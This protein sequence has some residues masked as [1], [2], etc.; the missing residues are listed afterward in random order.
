[1]KKT[2]WIF[3]GGA[4]RT[5]YVAG[6][7]YA[8]CEMDLPKPDIILAG[9]G[10]A[11][12]CLTYITKQ[13]EVIKKIWCEELYSKRFINFFRFWKIVDI[14]YL[15]DDLMKKNNPLKI[16]EVIKSDIKVYWPATDSY[17]GNIKYFSNH[18]G[19]DVWQILK[20][21]KSS[22]IFTNTFSVK[23]HKIGDRYYSDSLASS[24]Y[25]YH[26]KKMLEEGVERIIVID[27]YHPLDSYNKN[28]FSKIY[29][30]LRNRH[31]RKNQ[32]RA[33]REIESFVKPE[34]VEFIKISPQSRLA[35][36]RFGASRKKGLEVFDR[37]YQDALNNCE[38]KNL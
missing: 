23:G 13:K 11:G 22:P 26:V 9:S 15:I 12:T 33:I 20:A 19:V 24:R 27:S 6:A 17:E 28:T 34:G 10:S 21:V 1:M 29:A 16:D 31:F 7:L 25:Q 37:G 5:V 18:D 35:M 3:S 8:M 4:A 14:D 36:S 38:L 32:L 2:A 30:L